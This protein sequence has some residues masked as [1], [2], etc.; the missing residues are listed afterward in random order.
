MDTRIKQRLV[1]LLVFLLLAAI[2]APLLFRSPDQVRVALD[3]DIPDP[4]E[5]EVTASA[6]V[7]TAAEEEAAREQIAA[8][9]EEI[10]AAAEKQAEQEEDAPPAGA[11]AAPKEPFTPTGWMVQVASFTEAGN[12]S[13]LETRLQAADYNAFVRETVQD[14]VTYYRVFAGPEIRRTEAQALRDRLAADTRF[15]LNGLL[16]PFAP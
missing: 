7:V 1:G 15:K 4:P 12:A 3:L 8:A 11:A 13:A 6:P 5:L 16:L 14:E 9:R 2:A 10:V